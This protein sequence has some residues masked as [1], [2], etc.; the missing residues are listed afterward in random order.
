MNRSE[1]EERCATRHLGPWWAD[2]RWLS[3]MVEAY[4]AGQLPLMARAGAEDDA[5][6]GY[7]M[8][9]PGIAKVNIIGMMT[10]GVSKFGGTSTIRTRQALRR[11]AADEA[12][13]A[14]LLVIDSP[15]GTVAGIGELAA[16]VVAIAQGMLIW[17]H[18]DDLAASAAYYIAAGT[19]RITA[20]QSA[21]VGSLGTIMTIR[22]TSGKATKD[23]IVVHAL[24]S[25]RH[26]ST[27]VD[28]VPI[29]DEQLAA[30]QELVDALG[31]QL[32]DH[33]NRSRGLGLV[34]GAGA[35]DGRLFV[36]SAAQG[37]GLI[38]GTQRYETTLAE[39]AERVGKEAAPPPQTRRQRDA[40]LRRA[41]A[42]ARA[43]AQRRLTTA[44]V[45]LRVMDASMEASPETEWAR[46]RQR[47]KTAKAMVATMKSGR[48]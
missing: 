17:T 27:G 46:A 21:L 26:K 41:R 45:M 13:Q 14:I 48:S 24:T 8:V 12:V 32:L 39:L 40:G 35:A 5:E 25:G 19:D 10:K 6:Y 7:R 4:R 42:N 22:D 36:A 30:E 15:G 37:L 20:N 23:G 29:T 34:A 44:K 31:Q 11:A 9:A 16:D 28:G 3:G 1:R 33:V 38:D 2:A 47:A 18:V 43:A